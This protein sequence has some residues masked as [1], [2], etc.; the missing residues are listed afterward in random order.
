MFSHCCGW[1][2]WGVFATNPKFTALIE[3][4]RGD[5]NILKDGIEIVTT[6]HCLKPLKYFPQQQQQQYRETDVLS[7]V[8]S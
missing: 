4:N 1:W 8:P 6:S 7:S 2:G 3:Q 5:K